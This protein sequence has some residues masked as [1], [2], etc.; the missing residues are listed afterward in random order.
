MPR[1]QRFKDCG[2]NP[3]SNEDSTISISFKYLINKNEHNHKRFIKGKANG[4]R[5]LTELSSILEQLTSNTYSDIKNSGKLERGAVNTFK[6]DNGSLYDKF[7][8]IPIIQDHK[9]VIYSLRFGSDDAYRLV[10]KTDCINKNILYILAYDW[11][12]DLYKH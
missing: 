7:K 6:T 8:S 11:N 4:T 3:K 5:A 9:S 12:H 10:F 2:P 1:N